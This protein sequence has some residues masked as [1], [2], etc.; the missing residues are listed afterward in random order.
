MKKF[1][2]HLAKF[3]IWLMLINLI[4]PFS[5]LAERNNPGVLIVNGVEWQLP[6]TPEKIGDYYCIPVEILAK[7]FGKTYYFDNEK[8]LVTL[9]DDIHGKVI[10]VH[11]AT[12][13][14]YNGTYYSCDPLFYVQDNI[15][16]I[17]TYFWGQLY[18]CDFTYNETGHMITSDKKSNRTETISYNKVNFSTNSISTMPI[19]IDGIKSWYGTNY[20]MRSNIYGSS[21]YINYTNNLDDKANFSVYAAYYDG[22]DRLIGIVAKDDSIEP[23]AGKTTILTRPNFDGKVPYKLKI[24][25]WG[26]SMEPLSMPY[27]TKYDYTV[28]KLFINDE[29]LIP[30]DDLPVV[31]DGNSTFLIHNKM[32]MKMLKNNPCFDTA[33]YYFLISADTIELQVIY[34]SFIPYPRSTERLIIYGDTYLSLEYVCDIIGYKIVN[35]DSETGI[36]KIIT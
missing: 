16:M 3:L 21:V 17:A 27:E 23:L 19:K 35:W 6:Q 28:V 33:N 12:E 30:D 5:V 29:E 8:K 26:K 4:M 31:M 1:R 18:D 10:L 13:F 15:P 36:L 11:N 25:M 22:R 9:K 34:G 14:Y 7:A 20:D 32:V 24:F 2:A